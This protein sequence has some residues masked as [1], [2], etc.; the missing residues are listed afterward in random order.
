MLTV[1]HEIGNHFVR[2]VLQKNEFKV[3]YVA[4]MKALAQEVVGKFGSRLR[5]LGVSVR[6]LTGRPRRAHA[7]GTQP[8]LCAHAAACLCVALR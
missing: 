4:P 8:G 5:G 1:C 6:E 2:G 7:I 3:I